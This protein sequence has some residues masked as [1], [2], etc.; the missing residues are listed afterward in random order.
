VV[1]NDKTDADAKALAAKLIP[2]KEGGFVDPIMAPATP[3]ANAEIKGKTETT[4]SAPD[5]KD[6]G[7]VKDPSASATN[8]PGLEAVD[9]TVAGSNTSVNLDQNAEAKALADKL[10]PTVVGDALNPGTP[11]H[12]I[13]EDNLTPPVV[14]TG[15]NKA[16]AELEA[17]NQALKEKIA[18]LE[19]AGAKIAERKNTL[20]S[21]AKDLTDKDILDDAKFD[22]AMNAKRKSE[23]NKASVQ[24]AEVGQLNDGER[25][26]ALKAEI[27]AKAFKK[28]KNN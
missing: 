12:P 25:L 27:D 18:L 22:V 21:F 3:V 17:E 8:V 5:T 11:L 26:Q 6:P 1:D 20:G 9:K 7:G 24:I 23:L 13:E 28:F 15:L 14:N 4:V 10:I 16:S 2:E 19:T